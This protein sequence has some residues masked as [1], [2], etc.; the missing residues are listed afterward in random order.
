MITKDMTKYD[1][2]KAKLYV[3]F[4]VYFDPKTNQ[5]MLR[6]VAEAAQER[7]FDLFEIPED[8]QPLPSPLDVTFEITMEITPKENV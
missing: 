5:D 3:E 7:I 8:E 1:S 6:A 4:R 2:T